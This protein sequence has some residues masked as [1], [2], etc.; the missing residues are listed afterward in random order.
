MKHREK[1]SEKLQGGVSC[2]INSICWKFFYNYFQPGLM[3]CQDCGHFLAWLAFAYH[4]IRYFL[5]LFL[6]FLALAYTKS[7]F[8]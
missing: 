5:A 6:L 4:V 3:L 7:G 1:I 2:N 8:I